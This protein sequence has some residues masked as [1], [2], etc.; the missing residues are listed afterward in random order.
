MAQGEKLD[1]QSRIALALCVVVLATCAGSAAYFG[2]YLFGGLLA[3]L[4]WLLKAL[5][6]AVFL[7]LGAA[8]GVWLLSKCF[9][10]VFSLASTVEKHAVPRSTSAWRRFRTWLWH[11]RGHGKLLSA[12]ARGNDA[13]V[14]SLL[15]GGADV[16][17]RGLFGE[18]PLHLAAGRG[19]QRMV[20]LLLASGG[21]PNGVDRDELRPLHYAVKSRHRWH[22]ETLVKNGADVNA[23]AADGAT[24]LLTALLALPEA[25]W[26]LGK[27]E[28]REVSDVMECLL[29]SGADANAAMPDPTRK[30]REVRPLD[31]TLEEPHLVY[32]LTMHG[33]DPEYRTVERGSTEPK[34]APLHYMAQYSLE[35]VK[36]LLDAGADVNAENRV[37]FTPLM[38]GLSALGDRERT[39]RTRS[40]FAAEPL[41]SSE[42]LLEI[43]THLLANGAT[44]DVERKR[45]TTAL[46][47]AAETGSMQAV[48]ALLDHGVPADARSKDGE[49][50]LL[51]V[52]GATFA[53]EHDPSPW[54]D[55][56]RRLKE[57]GADPRALDEAGRSALHRAAASK[58]HR[59]WFDAAMAEGLM[60]N[61]MDGWGNTP[62]HAAA[63]N[64][65]SEGVKILLELGA[66]A[67]AKNEAGK[68]PYDVALECVATGRWRRESQRAFEEA[69]SLLKP[70]TPP[71]TKSSRPSGEEEAEITITIRSKNA[72][73]GGK[74]IP[75]RIA[76]ELAG[77]L[78]KK[79]E[80]RE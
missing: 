56:V 4:P 55:V 54:L 70:P 68:S 53:K 23:R 57:K 29:R 64:L 49:T 77:D 1:R 42:E 75:E 47:L 67:R 17:E 80:R 60:L 10:D 20:E 46:H 72:T 37:H 32:L 51:A 38:M 52:Y 12:V 41:G 40:A 22:M 15:R 48:N 14:V 34:N 78:P 61:C 26:Q 19:S 50:P 16:H 24:P 69:L 36:R 7:A 27:E 76:A 2:W 3:R 39:G 33:L 18:T 13:E 5:L 11:A 8:A 25:R 62:L 6:Y 44:V 74:R 43:F 66:S 58:R 79:N 71:P 28:W 73:E 21:D 30:T 63:A 31:L 9:D 59:A 35:A 45:G 65:N